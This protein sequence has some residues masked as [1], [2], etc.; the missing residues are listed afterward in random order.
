MENPLNAFAFFTLVAVFYL[1]AKVAVRVLPFY[2]EAIKK[3][4]SDSSVDLQLE[5]LRGLL[6]LGV[7]LHHSVRAYALIVTGEWA[8]PKSQLFS[9]LAS[10]PVLFFFYLSGY[11]FW[12]KFLRTSRFAIS[13]EL[14][15][16]YKKRI[17]R[18]Y[19]A[20]TVAVAM[21]LAIV[22]ALSGFALK[23]PVSKIAL[24]TGK[25]VS[26]LDVPDINGFTGTWYIVAGVFW[27][28]QLELMF[29]LVLPFLY[30]FSSGRRIL[31]LWIIMGLL[32][33][34]KIRIDM[35]L[36]GHLFFLLHKFAYYFLVGFSG[37]ILAAILNSRGFFPRTLPMW[38]QS[39]LVLIPLVLFFFVV[40]TTHYSPLQSVILF[41]PFWFISAGWDGW[42]TLRS[43]PV[44]FLGM[45]S[46]SVYLFHGI[47]LFLVTRF[48][49]AGWPIGSLSAFG[50][51]SLIAV[52]GILVIGWS[53]FTYRFIEHFFIELSTGRRR[54]KNLPVPVSEERV[55]SL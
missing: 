49:D 26:L 35:V 32:A 23:E 52:T 38:L 17:L 51:W 47:F 29:Y 5:G 12:G 28:L 15:G 33:T 13:E 27:T 18:L 21:L 6:A 42:G 41:V 34:Y 53:S 37:G 2:R 1:T 22:F 36:V 10:G 24:E 54:Y 50:Y 31:L 4:Q 11:L 7:F 9:M 20:L 25:W 16:F 19:P 44:V 39:G 48:V 8:E 46:Y 30:W 45:I 40:P 14:Y 43:A 55:S 3:K